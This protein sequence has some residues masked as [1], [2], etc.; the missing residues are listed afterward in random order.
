MDLPTQ[1]LS[2]LYGYDRGTPVDRHCIE[3]FL[4]KHADRVRGHV[5]E[6]K[7]DT[8][9]R[10]FGAHRIH[11]VIV[12][13]VDPNNTDATLIADLAHPGSLPAESFDCII[14]T[15]T[16]QFVPDLAAA[17]RNCHRALKPG[18]T[19]LLTAPTV[20]RVSHGR[21]ETDLWR[22]TPAGLRRLLAGWPGPV[23]VTGYGNL[24]ACI[25]FLTGHAA[26]ELTR[27]QLH[28]HDPRFPLVACAAA[29]V[30]SRLPEDTHDRPT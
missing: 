10:R 21:P 1:P 7:D 14:C 22:L 4:G 13:D 26:E 29:Q 30:P 17:V 12:V 2:D 24:A 9:A 28:Y 5:A 3:A 25:A 16:V 8:Y 18:G 6:I 20:S 23:T 27:H 11:C 15:Q 19:L